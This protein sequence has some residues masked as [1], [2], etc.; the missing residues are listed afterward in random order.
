MTNTTPTLTIF[1]SLPGG[2]KTTEAQ[3]LLDAGAAHGSADLY[4]GLYSVDADGV[5]QIDVT[6]LDPAH[7][8]SLKA[9]IEALSTGRDAVSDNTNLTK[10][11]V[12]PYVAVAQAFRA[13]CVIV[14]VDTDAETAFGRQTHGVPFAVI[15][16]SES[17]E[18][19]KTYTFGDL[20]TG[21]DES[22]VGGFVTMID[23]FNDYEA[24]FHW[25]FLPWLTQRTA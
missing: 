8:A 2:G 13:N 4:P 7:G 20:R 16:N 5:M 19:R 23:R 6:K 10:D 1:R 25:Q 17:G 18:I 24:P 21:A 14:T 11:E 9:V 22:V 15:R 3:P 12:I